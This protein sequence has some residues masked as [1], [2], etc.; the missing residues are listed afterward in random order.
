MKSLT[1]ESEA[2]RALA[3]CLDDVPFADVQRVEPDAVVDGNCRADLLVDVG[4]SDRKQRLVVEVK[5]N[6][7]P[8]VIRDM[9][10]QLARFRQHMP[11]AY[12]VVVAP[13]I[14]PEGAAICAREGIGYV[15][16]A[17]NCR[18]T[19]GQVYIRRDGNPNPFARKRDLRTLYSPKAARV[20]RVLLADPNRF[21]KVQDLATEASVSLG[22]VSNVKKLLTDRDPFAVG[23]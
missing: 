2:A 10:N 3:E 17:G 18:L 23:Q 6:G 21:W 11:D 1:I 7:Q 14:S 15:D 13:Y 12:G 8:R 9:V 16:L 19:F 20:L 5:T 4:L 22:E